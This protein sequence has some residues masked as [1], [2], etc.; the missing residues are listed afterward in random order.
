MRAGP[1]IAH[2][3]CTGVQLQGTRAPL[4][5]VRRQHRNALRIDAQQIRLRHEAG[6]GVR[7]I[8]VHAP[9][10]QHLQDLFPNLFD[11]HVLRYCSIALHSLSP[12]VVDVSR[13]RGQPVG[14]APAPDGTAWPRGRARCPVR[15]WRPGWSRVRPRRVARVAGNRC[16]SGSR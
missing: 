2:D 6:R 5:L 16:A 9:G 13:A 10:L 11:R 4:F 1:A 12:L 15:G 8:F 3:P 14:G 7:Q